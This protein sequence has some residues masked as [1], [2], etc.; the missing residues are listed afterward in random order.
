MQITKE[1]A[2]CRKHNEKQNSK[3]TKHITRFCA[4][5]FQISAWRMAQ[6]ADFRCQ[7][8]GLGAGGQSVQIAD[9]RFQIS[10]CRRGLGVHQGQMTENRKQKSGMPVQISKWWRLHISDVKA[11]HQDLLQ[12][13]EFRL[14]MSRD[15]RKPCFS[16]FTFQMADCRSHRQCNVGLSA[17]AERQ[18]KQGRLQ[19]KTCY[20]H[21]S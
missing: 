9:N 20:H 1:R 18:K 4:I 16:C 17:Q 10:E 21:Y 13:T 7:N 11:A 2:C 12:I 3:T 5:W 8:G 6:I 15:S 14:Q 19:R